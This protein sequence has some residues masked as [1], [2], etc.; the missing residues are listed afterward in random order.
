MKAIQGHMSKIYDPIHGFIHFSGIEKDLVDSFA[1]QRL[2]YIHQLGV[3]HLVYPGAT[4][5]RFEHSLGT[6][7]LATDIFDRVASKYEIPRAGYWRQVLRLAA[8]CHDLGHLPFSHV[9]EK[10]LLGPLGHELWTLKIITSEQLGSIW[11]DVDVRDVVKMAVGESKL[12]QIDACAEPFSVW[13]RVLS[14][15]ISGDFF[16]ADR[17]DYLLRDARCTGVAYGL[18][19]YHQLIEMLRIIPSD[20]RLELGVEENGIES[21][22]AL[23][24]ARHFMHRRV[25]QYA[26]VKAYSFHMMRFMC[27]L[28][29]PNTVEEYLGYYDSHVLSALSK[30]HA[31]GDIDATALFVREKRF[32]VLS[33]PGGLPDAVFDLVKQQLNIPDVLI[34]IEPPRALKDRAF[35][36]F[37]VMRQDLGVVDAASCSDMRIPEKPVR[38]VYLASE[39][40]ALFQKHMQ[41][42]LC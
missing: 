40:E 1:F 11:Q 22:E 15:I 33:F 27:R 36:S 10:P 20:G 35:L 32:R 7:K 2:H 21:C 41:A 6:M 25:Y 4:H 38:L 17:I 30:A 3:A 39:Y 18:F 34:G 16:G 8:L 24:L 23:L 28:A 31:E 9:A 26:S 12:R 37:P 19:D 29:V 13:E 14:Q 5:T 42:F